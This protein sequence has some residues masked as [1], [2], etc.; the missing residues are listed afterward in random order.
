MRPA[1]ALCRGIFVA[2]ITVPAIVSI[3][4]VALM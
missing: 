1:R 2:A 4:G 3:H